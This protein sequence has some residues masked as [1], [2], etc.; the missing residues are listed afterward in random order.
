MNLFDE[1]K[2]DLKVEKELSQESKILLNLESKYALS[3]IEQFQILLKDGFKTY[4]FSLNYEE[5][6]LDIDYYISIVSGSWSDDEYQDLSLLVETVILG[7]KD[8]PITSFDLYRLD[9]IIE[10]EKIDYNEQSN[11][12]EVEFVKKLKKV[13]K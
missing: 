6:E 2:K 7:T 4:H 13:N 3:K 9:G 12:Q 5:Y 10:S 11:N 8:Y 1:F